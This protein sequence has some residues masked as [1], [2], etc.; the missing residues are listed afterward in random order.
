MKMLAYHWERFELAE[1]RRDSC[2]DCWTR[3]WTGRRSQMLPWLLTH[4]AILGDFVIGWDCFDHFTW[5]R[6]Q[7][8]PNIY[9]WKW[10]ISSNPNVEYF[11]QEISLKS[12]LQTPKATSHPRYFETLQLQHTQRFWRPAWDKWLATQSS[13]YPQRNETLPSSKHP[14]YLVSMSW[15]S[16]IIKML[17]IDWCS[18]SPLW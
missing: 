5:S 15:S 14:S 9:W 6:S 3:A 17:L 2:W 11:D 12:K 7:S 13:S 1:F 18:W 4:L 16:N 10:R 8:S